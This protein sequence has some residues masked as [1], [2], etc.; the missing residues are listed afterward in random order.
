MSESGE[1]RGGRPRLEGISAWISGAG[2]GIGRDT[3]RLFAREGAFVAAC[4]RDGASA[5]SVAHEIE[6]AGGRAIAVVADVARSAEVEAAIRTSEEEAGGLHVLFNNAGVFPGEDGSPVDTPE[7]VWEQVIDINLKGVFLGCKHGI[8]ALL[9]AGGGSIINTASFVA[10]V[11]A[12]T[13]QI[14]YTASKGGVLA[15][16][17][18]IAVEYARQGI[19]ANAL[20]PGPVNTPLLE[21]LLA[22]PDARARRFVHLPMGR[23]AESGEIAQAALFLASAES[24]YVS[25]STFLVDGGLTAAYVTAED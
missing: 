5:E 22:D 2:S 1:N 18:E 4:D 13:S 12:A 17:R 25:G 16:T 7:E 3:A 21:Q 15:M 14:A 20:C 11:G 9:R 19:R 8:P 6:S 10:V 24:S 23:L